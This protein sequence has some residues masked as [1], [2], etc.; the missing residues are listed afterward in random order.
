[1]QHAQLKKEKKSLFI[2]VS[3]LRGKRKLIF[4]VNKQLINDLFLS[5][6]GPTYQ[7]AIHSD[8]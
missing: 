6:F 7:V 2:S 4:G 1:M 5:P 3:I 8:K